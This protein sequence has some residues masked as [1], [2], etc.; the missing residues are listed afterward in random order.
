MITLTI[1]EWFVQLMAGL[2]YFHAAI[3]LWEAYLAT[4]T[5]KLMLNYNET[6]ARGEDLLKRMEARRDENN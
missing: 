1:P 6:I 2:L 3:R 4:K 5:R